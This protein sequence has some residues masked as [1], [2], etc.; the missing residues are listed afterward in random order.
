MRWLSEFRPA[1]LGAAPEAG[2]WG[3]QDPAEPA[4]QPGV[5][6]RAGAD[7]PAPAAGFPA[8][9]RVASA[10]PQWADDTRTPEVDPED[11]P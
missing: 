8:A 6:T 2:P 4:Y 10:G 7:V 3:A 1:A 5:T 9:G 11:L